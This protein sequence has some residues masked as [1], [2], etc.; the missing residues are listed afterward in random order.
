MMHAGMGGDH[1]FWVP[2]KTNDRAN[3]EQRLIVRSHWGP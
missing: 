2:V 3:P 1:E